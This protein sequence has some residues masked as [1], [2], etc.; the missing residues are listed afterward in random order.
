MKKF[1]T[2][3]LALSVV[4][5]YSFSSVGAV[6]AADNYTVAT[7]KVELEAVKTSQMN[8]ITA[9][10]GTLDFKYDEN[11]NCIE[12]SGLTDYDQ[13]AVEAAAKAL[14]TAAGKAMDDAIKT[15]LKAI[16]ALIKADT[17]VTDLGTYKDAVVAA[18][19]S[20][21]S[22]N[23]TTKDGFIAALKADTVTLKE[24]KEKTTYDKVMKDIAENYAL[25]K[26]FRR[27]YR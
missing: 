26:Y 17:P 3:L 1:L 9:V 11:G 13:A 6:F 23:L 19:T 2:V 18:V 4:F 12:P 27:C 21:K 8:L 20:Y 16:D 10:K 25:S 7:A 24:S 5:T 22:G 14:E 15:Q